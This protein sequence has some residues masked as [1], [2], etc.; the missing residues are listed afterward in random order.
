MEKYLIELLES[1]NRVIVPD[2]GAFIIR[3]QEPR[4]LVFNDLL[5]FNDGMLTAHIKQE[6]GISMSKAQ[7]RI[8]EFV[9]QV[10]K[11][12]T[13]GDIYH[14]EN[15]GYLK[16]DDSSKIEFSVSRFPTVSAEIVSASTLGQQEEE[17]REEK[18]EP[19]DEETP[20]GKAPV[21]ETAG[22]EAPE[23]E[24]PDE[25]APETELPDEE[26]PETEPPD[27]EVPETESPGEE[28]PVSEMPEEKAVEAGPPGEKEP[29]TKVPVSES[30][31][32]GAPAEETMEW[33]DPWKGSEADSEDGDFTLEDRP[34]QVEVDAEE[35]KPLIPDAEEPPFLIEE[36]QQQE[37]KKVK[38]VGT[39]QA[40]LEAAAAAA[41]EEEKMESRQEPVS[42]PETSIPY[43]YERE[44][45][46]RNIWPWVGGAIALIVIL[47]V[48]AWFFFPAQ[49]NR[50]LGGKSTETEAT[51]EIV[52]GESATASQ[53][54]TGGQEAPAGAAT[55]QDEA[56]AETDKPGDTEA[57]QNAEEPVAETVE[58]SPPAH[59][60]VP[61]SARTKKFYIVAG[62]FSNR[63]NATNYVNTLKAEGHDAVM[64]GPRNNLYGVSFGSYESRDAALRE[65]ERIKK[66]FNPQAWLLYY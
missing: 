17:A 57:G 46:I 52:S 28:A 32:T 24:L 50:I 21:T 63:T 29:E 54:T 41:A 26:A 64:F 2:L 35:D 30:T 25:E 51:E 9:D 23:S 7:V 11:V 10:K 4:E 58:E 1:N 27:E 34:G 12:L 49:F 42:E 43:Y 66:N 61:P 59:E 6:E 56:G 38:V 14:L 45:S 31:E 16:M 8:E 33:E 53:E 3:Q 19:A 55:D 40:R 5:A 48:A 22:E 18:P 36:Q 39:S 65:L 20:D 47:I 37:E 44:R 60:P 13:K 62:M 15:L